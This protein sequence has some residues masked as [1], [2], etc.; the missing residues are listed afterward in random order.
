MT[1][2]KLEPIEKFRIKERE[3][4]IKIFQSEK[5]ADRLSHKKWGKRA[6]L[7]GIKMGTILPRGSVFNQFFISF[8]PYFVVFTLKS[9]SAAEEF[10]LYQ[11][12]TPRV[13]G[14]Q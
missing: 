9:V 7:K 11:K 14:K 13:S 10:F 2:G 6:A 12:P 8:V 3:T 5:C 1:S 4:E